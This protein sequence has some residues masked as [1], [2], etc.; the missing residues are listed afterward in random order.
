[1]PTDAELKRIIEEAAEAGARK[2]LTQIGLHDEAA[3]TDVKELRS[4]L[5]LWRDTRRT[6]V[7]TITRTITMA[8]L[9]A[10][11]AGTWYSYWPK[12]K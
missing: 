6:V 1:M 9:A 7:Q 8:I 5:E 3:G 12:D 4:L 10:I 2:A 11:A